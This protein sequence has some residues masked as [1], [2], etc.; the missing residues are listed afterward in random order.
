MVLDLVK[1]IKNIK[2]VTKT[3][4]MERGGSAP[5]HPPVVPGPRLRR[6]ISHG[7]SRRATPPP[8]LPPPCRGLSSTGYFSRGRA[9]PKRHLTVA[10]YLPHAWVVC[11][12]HLHP[13]ALW[14]QKE[15]GSYCRVR[16]KG[17]AAP[18]DIW[19]CHLTPQGYHHSRITT[20]GYKSC[21]QSTDESIHI[22][23]IYTTSTKVETR[24]PAGL[25]DRPRQ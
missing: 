11:A 16:A 21:A 10:K 17:S 20:W 1:Y 6:R 24:M 9:G 8:P 25:F 22:S 7:K 2:N 4:E 13:Y 19:H 18:Q 15:P 14:H 12:T 5:P 23:V 3:W